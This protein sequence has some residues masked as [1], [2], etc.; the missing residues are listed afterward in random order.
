MSFL[1]VVIDILLN[2]TLLS[3]TNYCFKIVLIV[4]FVVVIGGGGAVVFG[5]G[6]GGGAA[7]IVR[8]MIILYQSHLMCQ[9]F[10]SIFKDLS[11]TLYLIYINQSTIKFLSV[12]SDT[13]YIHLC[14]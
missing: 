14:Y 10:N 6:G 8:K 4:T 9:Y 13:K 2:I 5:G 12:L 3:V 11:Y 7:A 1:I